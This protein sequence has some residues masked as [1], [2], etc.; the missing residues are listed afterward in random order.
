MKNYATAKSMVGLMNEVNGE[1]FLLTLV[2]WINF[3]STYMLDVLE[4]ASNSLSIL[5]V[6]DVILFTTIFYF[7]VEAHHKVIIKE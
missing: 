4:W 5:I 1:F 6:N 2:I 3:V 7:S